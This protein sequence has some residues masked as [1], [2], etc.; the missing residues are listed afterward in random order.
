ML[1]ANAVVT[2]AAQGIGREITN[3]LIE[4]GYF[5]LGIDWNKE[6]LDQVEQ[7]VNAEK[8]VFKG[9]KV[10]ISRYQEVSSTVDI[11]KKK[12]G[13]IDV[14][15][16][17]AG[18]GSVGPFENIPIEEIERV[19]AVN[20]TGPLYMAKAIMPIMVEKG[21]GCVVNVS[22][23]AAHLGGGLLGNT[24]YAATKGGIISFSKG[25]ARE[26]G[27]LGIRS[28]CVAPG[29]TITPMTEENYQTQKER[30]V[31][32][33]PL[34]RPAVPEEIANAVVFLLSEQASYINGETLN[35]DGGTVRR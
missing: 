19:I 4:E 31:Q 1:F 6:M 9:Y 7:E 10:D 27:P 11:I 32:M 8:E 30:L 22:S 15:V 2:G 25:L 26:Y 17:N 34:G 16:N 14:L 21:K 23:I 20:L 33:I 18:I 5:V 28:N 3:K 29:L 13:H 35:V 24:L 12:H